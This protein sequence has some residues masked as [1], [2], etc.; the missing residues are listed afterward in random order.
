MS[1][2]PSQQAVIKAHYLANMTTLNDEQAR[3]AFNALVSP[4]FIVWKTSVTSSE[5]MLNG[6]DWT[7]V[8]NLSIGKSRIWEWMFQFGTIDASKPNIRAGIDATWV[9]TAADLAVRAA[10]YV[11]CKRSAT[12]AEK[13]LA[14]GT[15][16]DASPATMEFEG[17]LTTD[18]VVAALSS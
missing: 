18:D 2:T 16:S 4:D 12:L 8:D 1:L 5:V 11:H 7:R 6:F 17:Q 15:G 3:D 13:L 10:V 9:G 14:T